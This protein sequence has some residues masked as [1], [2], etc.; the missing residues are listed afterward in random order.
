VEAA[1]VAICEK[2][3]ADVTEISSDR[4]KIF[5]FRLLRLAPRD[6]Q[7]RKF[8]AQASHGFNLTNR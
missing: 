3:Y 5:T 1:R 4:N 8:Q 7:D 2:D 6:V